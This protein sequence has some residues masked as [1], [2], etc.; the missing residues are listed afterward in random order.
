MPAQIE[1][2]LITL[3]VAASYYRITREIDMREM[4]VITT[5]Q[6]FAFVC[7]RHPITSDNEFNMT[8]R[9]R[10]IHP[11]PSPREHGASLYLP[12]CWSVSRSIVSLL[13]A[14]CSV[15]FHFC[16]TLASMISRRLSPNVYLFL[17]TLHIGTHY[18]PWARSFFGFRKADYSQWNDLS[19]MDTYYTRVE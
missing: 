8:I 16:F 19:S 18:M 1:N 2:D 7:A 12:S 13:L 14:I 17:V 10:V 6:L 9:I 11:I 15:L 4:T 5:S 3:K